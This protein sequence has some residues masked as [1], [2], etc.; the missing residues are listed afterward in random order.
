MWRVLLVKARNNRRIGSQE[1]FEDAESRRDDLPRKNGLF[2]FNF[3]RILTNGTVFPMNARTLRQGVKLGSGTK[4]TGCGVKK[5][6]S[7]PIYWSHRSLTSVTL[8]PLY[9]HP[10]FANAGAKRLIHVLSL[11]KVARL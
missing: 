9:R 7:Q 8:S 6:R 10:Q 4:D 5:C 1:A 11:L 2:P 3:N